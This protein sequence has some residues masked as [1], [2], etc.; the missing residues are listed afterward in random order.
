VNTPGDVIL[1]LSVTT[2]TSPFFVPI[3]TVSVILIGE[4]MTRFFAAM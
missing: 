1:W 2:S 3:G 4:T